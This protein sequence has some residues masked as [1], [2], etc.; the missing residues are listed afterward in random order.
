MPTPATVKPD[1]ADACL[2]HPAQGFTYLNLSQRQHDV[3]KAVHGTFTYETDTKQVV[4]FLA[5]DTPNAQ[6]TVRPE[7]G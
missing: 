3:E 7:D 1:L 4:A 5:P 2:P 6:D